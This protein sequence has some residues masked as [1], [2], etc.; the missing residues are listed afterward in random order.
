MKT[1]FPLHTSPVAIRLYSNIPFDNTY[2]H[3]S[4]ISDL[5][6][7]NNVKL[8]TGTESYGGFAKERFINRIDTTSQRVYPSYDLTGEFNFDF[9]NGL[10][11]SV[12]LELTPQQTNANYMRVKV[13]DATHGYEY[14]YYFITGI[15][16]INADTYRLSLEL[17]VIMTYQDEF[18][19]GMKDIPVFTARKHCHRYTNNGI[20]PHCADFKKG[21]SAFAGIKPNIIKSTYS[22]D[23]KDYGSTFR[24]IKWLYICVDGDLW[25]QG[26]TPPTQ[27]D[28]KAWEFFRYKY[29]DVNLPMMML[30]IPLNANSITLTNGTDSATLDRY[31]NGTINALFH[32]LIG[33]GKYHGAK[34]SPYPPFS[35]SGA[36]TITIDSD[37]NITVRSIATRIYRVDTPLYNTIVYE[38]SKS[39]IIMKTGFPAIAIVNEYDSDFDLTSVNL[40]FSNTQAPTINSDRYLDPKLLFNPFTRYYISATYGESNEFFPEI[41]YSD[42]VYTTNTFSFS[43]IYNYYIGDYSIFTYLNSTFDANNVVFYSNYK[44]NNVGLSSSINYIMPVG[45]NA[46]DVFNATQANSFYTSKVA[47]GVTSGLSIIGGI[48]S[49]GMGAGMTAT[50]GG[51]LTPMGAG[52]VAGGAGAIAS[53]IAGIATNIKATNA[54]IEDLKNTPDSINVQGGSYVGDMSRGTIMP[55]LSVHTIGKALETQADDYF[56]NYGYEVARECYFNTEIKYDNDVSGIVDNNIFGRTIFNYVQ[57]NDDITNKINYDMPLIIKQKF[58]TILN[59]GITLWSFFGNTYLWTPVVLPTSS[60]NADRW[61]MKC[62]LDNT[63]YKQ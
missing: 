6:T 58:N 60:T 53:G 52:L 61:F 20:S 10:I 16:Q 19:T 12:V 24:D 63:E 14:Y 36:D 42:G 30:C 22:L 32:A 11:G 51:G 34:I 56:Y 23:L 59:N 62:I 9:S 31:S 33:S 1:A 7:Y 49:I 17:D 4:L 35:K 39:K 26:D 40:P 15:S 44:K 29:K 5:F 55:F 18:L 2:K 43:S 28:Y 48:A 3:H 50:S 8:F 45:T 13:G 38:N 54:K 47:S 57:T 21:D 27:D 46:L 37:R 25:H 41:I